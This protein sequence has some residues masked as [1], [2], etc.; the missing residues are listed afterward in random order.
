MGRKKT[1]AK[2]LTSFVCALAWAVSLIPLDVL[3]DPQQ[4]APIVENQ[5]GIEAQGPAEVQPPQLPAEKPQLQLVVKQNDQQLPDGGILYTNDGTALSLE[6]IETTGQLS[7]PL[8]QVQYSVEPAQ[9]ASV[10]DGTLHI[11]ANGSFTLTARAEVNGEELSDSISLTVQTKVESITS[12]Q[13]EKV[14]LKITKETK[15]P[16]FTLPVE[17]KGPEGFAPTTALEWSCKPEDVLSVGA[18]GTI[19]AL[20]KGE[21]VVTAKAD[22]KSFEWNVQVIQQVEEIVLADQTLYLKSRQ[23]GE[24]EADLSAIVRPDDADDPTLTWKSEQ[25]DIAQVDPSTGK[26]TALK[27]GTAIVTATAKDGS[28]VTAECTITVK[29]KVNVESFKTTP[30]EYNGTPEFEVVDVVTDAEGVSINGLKAYAEDANAGEDKPVKLDWTNASVDDENYA[31]GDC[32]ATGTGTISK[33]PISVTQL[34]FKSK[35]YDGTY[36]VSLDMLQDAVFAAGDVLEGDFIPAS[37]FV[38]S[39]GFTVNQKDAGDY[40]A[41]TLVV[42]LPQELKLEHLNYVLKE[43]QAA[44]VAGTMTILPR[45]VHLVL[46]SEMD[47]Y[48]DGTSAVTV[49][50]QWSLREDDTLA[51]EQIVVRTDITGWSYDGNYPGEYPISGIEADDFSFSYQGEQNATNNYQLAE[52]PSITG[53]ISPVPAG[54]L[55][56]SASGQTQWELGTDPDQVT[57]VMPERSADPDEFF[58]MKKQPNDQ[59]TIGENAAWFDCESKEETAFELAQG[60]QHAVAY[61]KDLATNVIYEV[62]VEYGYDAQAPQVGTI[63][64]AAENGEMGDSIDFSNTKLTYTLEVSDALSGVDPNSIQYCIA[65]EQPDAQ[66]VWNP[67]KDAVAV[68][69]GYQFDVTV[70]GSG[71][72]YVKVSDYAGNQN[73]GESVRALVLEKTAPTVK[74]TWTN[75]GSEKSHTVQVLAEETGE[76]QSG[77]QKIVY[78]LKDANGTPVA[79]YEVK[80]V[81]NSSPNSLGEIKEITRCTDEIVLEAPLNGTYSLEAYAVDFCGNRSATEVKEQIVVDNQ[82]PA[83]QV[84][85]T[86]GQK[87]TDPEGLERYYYNGENNNLDLLIEWDDTNSNEQL[88]YTVEVY[89]DADPE[90]RIVREGK[91]RQELRISSADIL[92]LPDGNIL[93]QVSSKDHAGNTQTTIAQANGVH[94]VN[95]NTQA[96]F[97]K[98]TQ[99]PV[100]QLTMGNGNLF[101][102]K[103]YYRADNCGIRIEMTDANAAVSGGAAVYTAS[104]DHMEK[105]APAAERRTIVYTTQEV[106]ALQDGSKN[107]TVVA[108]DAAGNKT[109]VLVGTGVL[110]KGMTATFELDTYAPVATAELS[111]G[112]VT[113]YAE[114]DYY[115]QDFTVCFTVTDGSVTVEDSLIRY[116][117]T[118]DAQLQ[119]EK[120]IQNGTSGVIALS[121]EGEYTFSIFGEDPAGNKLVYDAENSVNM[122]GKAFCQDGKLETGMKILD[123]TSPVLTVSHDTGA[124]NKQLQTGRRFYYNDGFTVSLAVQD[125]YLDAAGKLNVQMGS[126]L[127]ATD[128]TTDSVQPSIQLQAQQADGKSAAYSSVVSGLPNENGLYIF[129]VS[130]TDKAGNPIIWQQEQPTLTNVDEANSRPGSIITKIVA[131]DTVAP[132]MTVEMYHDAQQMDVFYKA[133]L[134]SNRYSIEKNLP[135]RAK[136]AATVAFTG[137]DYSTIQLDY[138]FHTSKD[139]QTISRHEEFYLSSTGEKSTVKTYSFEGQQ[140]YQL[141][142]LL[143]T[144]LAGNT[145]DLGDTNAGKIYLDTTDSEIINGK[146]ELTPAAQLTPEKQTDFRVTHSSHG[147][148]NPLYRED[149]QIKATVVDPYA[150]D[151]TNVSA[152]GLYKIFYKATVNNGQTDLTDSVTVISA[153]QQAGDP[154][155]TIQPGVI[156]YSTTGQDFDNPGEEIEDEIIT[157]KDELTFVFDAN[158]FNYNDVQITVWAQDNAGNFIAQQ[159]AAMYEFGID[160]TEPQVQ[161]SFDSSVDAKNEKYF[162]DTRSVTVTVTERN[163]E[164][165][166]TMLDTQIDVAAARQ[167]G[168]WTKAAGSAANGDL[169]T[170]TYTMDYIVDGDYSIQTATADAVDLSNSTV[171]DVIL[172]NGPG[173]GALFVIDKTIPV[174]AIDFDNN[175]VRNEKYYNEGRV[176]EIRIQE[177]NFRADEVKLSQTAEILEGEVSAPALSA[178]ETSSDMN[179]ATLNYA[180]DGDYTLAVEY[181]DLAGNEAEMVQADPFTVDTTAPELEITGVA[182]MAAYNAEVKPSI[183]YH[184][185]NHDATQTSL[186]IVGYKNTTGENLHGTAAENAQGGS[187]VCNNI[188]EIPENDDVYTCTGYVADLAG[189][190]TEVTLRFSVNRF[191]SNYILDEATQQVVDSYY[192]NEKPA[193]KVTEINVNS[194]EFTEITATCNGEIVPLEY[195]VQESGTADSWKSYEYSILADN[196]EQD[197]IYNIT[198]YSRDSAQNENS[199]RTSKVEEYIHPVDFVLDTTAPSAL[200]AGVE[201]RSQYVE[202][203]RLVTVYVEDNIKVDTVVFYLDDTAVSEFTAEDVE[204]A[205]GTLT[206]SAQSKN[207]WQNFR[208]EV[209]DKAGNVSGEQQ[210]SFLLTSNLFY[211]YINNTPLVAG[212]ILVVLLAA[213]A[214]IFL[215]RK[216]RSKAAPAGAAD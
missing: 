163:F 119:L 124:E 176:A 179:R 145:S 115:K 149:V 44:Q 22:D 103:Y 71:K 17:V 4:T 35:T 203:E 18:D 38:G 111:S 16:T 48:S 55:D 96:V 197:G 195:T 122:T 85:L 139:D 198:I 169:D 117:Y 76:F 190:E 133:L 180:Q 36:N 21:A 129:Q 130:G 199:N 165:E 49:Q 172:D 125:A 210:V 108:V 90:N 81:E 6:C 146:D 109:E 202:N 69:N 132:K 155:V 200:I 112:A 53:R 141:K 166:K 56:L 26:V 186:S 211:Q 1:T 63:Q 136:D 92:K 204:K 131:V 99:K 102:G 64:V 8:E 128:Y 84:T 61:L 140:T 138:T 148:G 100:V 183:V 5:P 105:D 152:S 27:N 86:N 137:L 142:N 57:I 134:D 170:W 62:S 31:V 187:F 40:T 51:G 9:A 87:G 41:P 3:G 151:Q 29:T 79:D 66:S 126:N 156:S 7:L 144:D 20:K 12:E 73:D 162:K 37:A 68:E 19:T 52:L 182:D 123:K 89:S 208:V 28:G 32:S 101:D 80:N 127:T 205:E 83:A 15:N 201:D 209:I 14:V 98:D 157:A 206:Y 25:P 143:V 59:L 107:V 30:K 212:S 67:V 10:A 213:A 54:T 214:V 77:I 78:T 58:W 121:E 159:N 147:T 160:V 196:F 184:D 91:T 97:V 70:E 34:N 114:A 178:W 118:K 153:N 120:E 161:V 216:K 33:K 65:A 171:S 94:L 11:A 181:T 116:R 88:A 158:T 45:P 23:A 60:E 95:Q 93:I 82:A 164:P 177:H 110:T 193:L 43:E 75:T 167:I 106:D 207:D 150:D 74:L 13:T 72:L 50:P 46:D 47:K 191:G 185:I 154:K 39:G 189:N 194:L 173:S 174:I 215:Q 113:E 175:N 192:V 24:D 104:L 42:D 188:P 2:R 135:Y 168:A